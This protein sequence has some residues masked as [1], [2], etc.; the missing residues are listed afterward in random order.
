MSDEKALHV[1]ELRVENVKRLTAVRIRPD[2]SLVIVGGQNGAGK[3]SLLD[4]IEMA[5][6][7]GRSIPVEPIRHGARKAR[8]VVDLGELVVE[9]TISAKGTQLVVRGK[10]GA[11]R[12]SPQALLDKLCSKVA[13][14]P[15]EFTRMDSKQQDAL[16]KR[17]LGL[18]FADLD[19]ARAKLYA[20]RA[21]HKR[22]AKKLEARVETMAEYR[23]V[24]A[25]PVDVSALTAEMRRV[26]DRGYERA[27]H[28]S[29][30]EASKRELANFD[31]ETMRR[32]S[33][34]DDMRLQ[35]KAL[36]A[37]LAKRAAERAAKLDAIANA[38][39]S[40]PEA[41]DLEALQKRINDAEAINAKVRANEERAR[42]VHELEASEYGATECAG[43][44]AAIDAEKAEKLAAAKFP[45]PGLGF[46]D[47]VGPTLNGVPLKQASS[48]EQLRLSVAIGAALNPRI[49]V[50]LVRDGSLLDDAS[51]RLL[52]ELAAATDSQVFV[53]RVGTHDA[54]AVIIEDGEV[55]DDVPREG[56]A[57]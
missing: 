21:E 42:L 33:Q 51:L 45:V 2:G 54:G 14:D 24:P 10:D 38:E 48:A 32:G 52:A 23:D 22:D 19:A 6:A 20:E 27:R 5:L 28:L 1:V 57:E 55:R 56:A 17:I 35:L 11:E 43:A 49:K 4:A 18:D 13:F 16:L 30:L 29:E 15:L 3:S 39:N 41:V 47:D 44:I 25:T 31:D 34:V 40:V 50:M 7:G 9:R 12:A 53:E 37:A 46:S 36:E 8:I 26:S